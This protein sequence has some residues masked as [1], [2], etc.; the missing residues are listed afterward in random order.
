MIAA[1]AGF[2]QTYVASGPQNLTGGQAYAVEALWKDGT[3]GDNVQFAWTP[4]WSTNVESIAGGYLQTYADPVGVS[5][6]ITSRPQ[7]GTL[8]ENRSM[9]FSVG[10]SSTPANALKSYQWQKGDGAGG[11]TNALGAQY[12]ATF[13]TPLLQYPADDGSQWRAIVYVPGSSVTS[14]VATVTVSDDVTPAV[15]L[16]AATV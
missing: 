6:N 11:F 14:E 15:V 4:P 12:G 7:G 2:S 13:T 10:A 5:V 8:E 16:A 3:G 9:T 1:Q